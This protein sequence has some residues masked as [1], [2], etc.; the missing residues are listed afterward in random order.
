MFPSN[1]N[2]DRFFINDVKRFDHDI[3]RYTWW[4]ENAI[5]QDLWDDVDVKITNR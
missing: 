1:Y 3:T 5:T 4:Y 2:S